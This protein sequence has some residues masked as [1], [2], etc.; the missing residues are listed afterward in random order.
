MEQDTQTSKLFDGFDLKEGATISELQKAYIEKTSQ[1]KFQR[2]ILNETKLKEDFL[3]YHD[4][5]LRLLK[6]YASLSPS[7]NLGFRYPEY[8]WKFMFNQGL[9]SLLKDNLILAGERFQEAYKLNAN[10]PLL[11]IYLGIILSWRKNYYAAEKYLSTAIKLD[12]ANDDAW[13]YLGENFFRAGALTKAIETLER[14]KRINPN[15]TEIAFKIKEI[16]ENAEV[17]RKKTRKES[18]WKRL[19]HAVA[20]VLR[21]KK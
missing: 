16:R 15:R 14:A 20:D 5:Y 17:R 10:Q 6:H 8:T 3:S 4:S 13:F 1:I 21:T 2:V 9:Y 7:I 19:I 18:T 11:L 12:T